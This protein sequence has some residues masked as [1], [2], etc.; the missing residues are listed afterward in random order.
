MAMVRFTIRDILWLTVVLALG[1]AWWREKHVDIQHRA[2]LDQRIDALTAK[3]AEMEHLLHRL[4]RYGP[5]IYQARF[6]G[7]RAFSD[8]KLAKAIGVRTGLRLNAYTAWESLR[9]VQRF[10]VD[11]GYPQATVTLLRGDKPGDQEL[12]FD[13]IEG[14]Y[15][16]P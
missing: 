8:K 7:N 10:Y 11:E 14:A 9:D 13:I 3:N 6:T 1:C 15:E 12:A 16:P 2:A 4:K 5:M